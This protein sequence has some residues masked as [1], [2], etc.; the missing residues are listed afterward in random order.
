MYGN[1][2]H[3]FNI[4]MQ[5]WCICQGLLGMSDS[6][7]C[8]KQ[9]V[10]NGKKIWKN[11]NFCCKE[12]PFTNKNIWF[13]SFSLYGSYMLSNTLVILGVWVIHTAFA[14]KIVTLR[15]KEDMYFITKRLLIFFSSFEAFFKVERANE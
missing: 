3:Q 2:W 8:N 5:F 4:L 12:I 1:G 14:I 10:I 6:H 15:A 7:C 11:V 13:Q 9:I